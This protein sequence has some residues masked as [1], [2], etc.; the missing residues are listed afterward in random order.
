MYIQDHIKNLEQL[1]KSHATA[2]SRAINRA[3]T[4]TRAYVVKDIKASQNFVFPSKYLK[5]RKSTPT[6]LMGVL[7]LTT[8]KKLSHKFFGA[9]QNSKGVQFRKPYSHG[10]SQINKIYPSAFIPKTL[11]KN[12]NTG[13]MAF[14]RESSARYPIK[15]VAQTPPITAFIEQVDESKVRDH[16]L[17]EFQKRYEY[18][19]KRL[20]QKHLNA[21]IEQKLHI[22]L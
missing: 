12:D 21:I 14:Q 18:E 13:Q 9:K 1:T 2:V 4:S 19:Q 20:A 7:W 3:V 11:N 5:I 6:T 8:K 10:D 17:K 16:Y 22:K 15:L